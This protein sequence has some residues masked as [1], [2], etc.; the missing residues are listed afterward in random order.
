MYLNKFKS[1]NF[2]FSSDSGYPVQKLLFQKPRK[3]LNLKK[4]GN[5]LRKKKTPQHISPYFATYKCINRVIKLLL[6]KQMQALSLAHSIY[7]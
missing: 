1:D 4:N 7:Y 5:E 6:P 2:E 3:L